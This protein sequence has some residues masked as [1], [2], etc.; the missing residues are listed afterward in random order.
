MSLILFKVITE[1]IARRAD[2]K[3]AD[4]YKV[5]YK[6]PGH[7]ELGILTPVLRK[8]M[9]KYRQDIMQ[10][11]FSQ[12][13]A[14]ALKFYK[15]PY[16]DY[17]LFANDILANSIAEFSVKDYDYLDKALNY[18]TGW[19]QVDDFCLNVL[20]P[21]LL[22]YSKTTLQFLKK[23][24]KSENM[25]KRRA[26]VVTFVRKI[27]ES[28]KFTK[29]CLKLCDNLKHDKEDLVLKAVGWALKDSM[30]GNKKEVQGYV[31]NLRKEQVSTVITLYAVRDL[32][33]RERQSILK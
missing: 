24:N 30:R 23:L 11:S 29:E 4:K 18:F 19:G 21:L 5:Y 13:K 1:D 20:Q 15:L 16:S 27:G 3:I 8:I 12:R 14:L 7:K 10:L 32:K 26:S 31:K 2:K 28:G 6:K 22:K 33:G 9:R 25:W 17:K